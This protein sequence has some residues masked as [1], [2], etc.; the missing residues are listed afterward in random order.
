MIEEEV[1]SAQKQ[2]KTK[3]MGEEE[4]L[5]LLKEKKNYKEY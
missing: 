3:F 2:N 4:K 1:K 5:Q